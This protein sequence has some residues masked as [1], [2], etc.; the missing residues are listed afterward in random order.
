[1]AQ[2]R[3]LKYVVIVKDKNDQSVPA[4]VYTFA[5]MPVAYARYLEEIAKGNIVALAFIMESNVD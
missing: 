5:N 3:S 4:E 2:G 1:M